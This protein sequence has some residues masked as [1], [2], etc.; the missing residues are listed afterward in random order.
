MNVDLNKICVFN[1][2]TLREAWS[3]DLNSVPAFAMVAF[4]NADVLSDAGKAQFITLYK[5]LGRIKISLDDYRPGLLQQVWDIFS[6][7]VLKAYLIRRCCQKIAALIDEKAQQI[8]RESQQKK[9]D[10]SKNTPA[11]SEQNTST[12]ILNPIASSIVTNPIIEKST[13][14]QATTEQKIPVVDRKKSVDPIAQAIIEKTDLVTHAISYMDKTDRQSDLDKSVYQYFNET[15]Q[16]LKANENVP[17]PRWY[18]T[19]VGRD[20]TPIIPILLKAKILEEKHCHQRSFFVPC[21]SSRCEEGAFSI[22]FDHHNSWN[23]QPVNYVVENRLYSEHEI[24]HEV[25]VYGGKNRIK[26]EPQN[27]AY[28]VALDNEI[29]KKINGHQIRVVSRE[30]NERVRQ[31]LEQ[32]E[33][34]QNNVRIVPRHWI[35]QTLSMY[36]REKPQWLTN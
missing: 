32:V 7:K 33:P 10:L 27:I 29:T 14:S 34:A 9:T 16:K 1:D 20:Y 21:A 24:H 4:S 2:L 25:K 12:S 23:N 11:L 6:L 13:T 26:F 15:L 18:H 35:K 30:F 19:F 22:A 28:F 8:I 17:L 36:C 31:I 5:S 3:L